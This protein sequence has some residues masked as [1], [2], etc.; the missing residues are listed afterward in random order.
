MKAR[1]APLALAVLA[2]SAV[3]GEIGSPEL[4]PEAAD[5]TLGLGYYYAPGEWTTGSRLGD[6]VANDITRDGFIAKLAFG[7]HEDLEVVAKAGLE[8]IGNEP[9]ATEFD[10]A[11]S[12]DG[13]FS[14]AAKG[15]VYRKGRLSA[16]P[17]VQY[18]EF[19]D[20]T[21]TGDVA[22]GLVL[23]P[24]TATVKSLHTLEAG[25]AA[26]YLATKC[27][28]FYGAYLY[29]AEADV[30][31]SFNGGPFTATLEEDADFG[32]YVGVNYPLNDKWVAT[33]ELQATSDVGVAVGLNYL[34]G[35]KAQPP[36]VITRTEK[37]VEVQKVVETVYV[38]KSVASGPARFETDV[39][40]ASGAAE[41]DS[42]YWVNIRQF[43]EFMTKYPSARGVIEGHCDCD[44]SDDFNQ[45]L[46]ERR[47]G[48]IQTLLVKLYGIDPQR[49]SISNFGEAKPI[50]DNETEA[51]KA[52][53]R[54]VRMVG[55]A[56]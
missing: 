16:G 3:A 20:Y 4:T 10:V 52:A 46:S 9:G 55:I 40:F 5:L 50:A 22:Q 12:S 44:G 48:A 29:Q 19:S 8:N 53:N 36:K 23:V 28:V 25:I 27:S 18:S 47:A 42:E 33:G 45:K 30:H 31:G 2:A 14:V 11:S 38:D 1:F 41:V 51:G 32:A 43:A 15:I 56:D 13:F 39:H 37:V 21:V 35:H 49:L 17:F 26:Q 24:L 7:L 34:I 54:R 6:R